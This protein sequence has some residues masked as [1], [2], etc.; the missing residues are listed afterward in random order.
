MA[1][2]ARERERERERAPAIGGYWSVAVAS[3]EHECELTS[4]VLACARTDVVG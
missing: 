1:P 3:S 4:S 2:Q